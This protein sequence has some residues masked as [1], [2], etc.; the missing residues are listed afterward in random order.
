MNKPSYIEKVKTPLGLIVFGTLMLEAFL[1]AAML[2]IEEKRFEL[3][4]IMVGFVFLMVIISLFVSWVKP[5]V[6]KG[7]RYS[8]PQNHNEQELLDQIQSLNE[9]LKKEK[10]ASESLRKENSLLQSKT[11]PESKK[12]IENQI[13]NHCSTTFSST[14]EE[15]CKKMGI[16]DSTSDQGKQV[17]VVLGAMKADGLINDRL[18]LRN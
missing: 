11:S 8:A 2:N 5:E 3:I 14:F 12:E 17:S 16:N 13:I 1:G 18:I 10:E 4:L 9:A 6:L 7:E 15:L